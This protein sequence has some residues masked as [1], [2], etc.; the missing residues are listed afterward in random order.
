M[1][2][3]DGQK[4]IIAANKAAA[5]AKQELKKQAAETHSDMSNYKDCVTRALAK[6]PSAME[7]IEIAEESA[8]PEEGKVAQDPYEQ[9]DSFDDDDQE[10]RIY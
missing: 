8:E 7:E 2:L 10:K 4:A 1:K 6:H 9:Y 3:T 5:L